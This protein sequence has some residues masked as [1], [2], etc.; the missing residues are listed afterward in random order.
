MKV[1]I[2]FSLIALL[3]FSC[4]KNRSPEGNYDPENPGYE[5]APQMYHSIPY[6]GLSQQV[7]NEHPFNEKGMNMSKPVEGTIARGKLSYFYP[8]EN[9]TEGYEKAGSELRNPIIATEESMARAKELY[10]SYC[11]HCHGAE[12]NSEGPVMA[13]GKFPKPHFGKFTNDYIKTLPDGKKYHTLTYGRNLMGSHASQ[14]NPEERWLLVH[15][16]NYLSGKDPIKGEG[17]PPTPVDTLNNNDLES[18]STST[19][20]ITETN[21]S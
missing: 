6:E 3:A 13:S 5:Y 10:V 7:E 15:Y 17:T 19:M 8:Y 16:V 11:T 4:S 12:G 9:S 1:Y 20:A 2:V 18:D 14:I 21:E